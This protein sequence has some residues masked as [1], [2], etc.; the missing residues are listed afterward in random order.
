MPNSFYNHTTYPT[1][2][3]PGSSAQMRAELQLITEAFDKL[4]TLSGAANQLVVVNGAANALTTTTALSGLT[5]TGS[6]INSSTIGASVPAGG[7]FTTLSATGAVSLGSSV[8]IAGGTING[9]QIGNTTP[10]SGAFTTLAA[11]SGITGNLTGNVTGNLTG[12]VTGNL[13]GNVTGNVTASS[14][15]STFTNVTINGTLNM[16]AGTTGTIENLSTPVNSGDAAPKGY[17]DTQVATRLALAGGTMSGAIVMGTNRITGMGDPVDAQDAATKIYV[18][19]AVQG[20]DAK[21]SCRVATTANITLS[22]AQTIDGVSVVAGNRVLVKNQSAAAENGIYVAAS[23]AWSRAPDA[24]TWDEL[25]HAFVFVEQ[26]TDGAN[27][28]YVCTVAAGGTLGTTAVTWVQFSG[29]GQIIA[30]TGLTKTGNTLNVNT[31]SSA[32]IVAGADEI[33]LATTGVVASTYKSVT[34]DQ[35]GRVTAGTNPTTLSGYGITDAYTSTQTDTLLSGKLSL[36]GGTMSGAIA[37]GTNKITG[38]GDPTNAQDAA[39]KNYTDS[40]LGSA[41]SAATSAAAALQ[42]EIN[43]AAS[44]SN[45]QT[46]AGNALTSANNAAA[47]YDAFDDRYLGSKTA[48]PTLDN[49]GNPLLE[50]ALYWNTGAKIMKVYD[51]ANWTASYLPATGYVQKTGDT[52]TGTLTAP[53]FIGPLTGNASTATALQ[54]A[55]TINGVSFDGTANITVADATKLPLTGGTV[56]GD[57]SFNG[58]SI[59]LGGGAI[60][61]NTRAGNLALSS[62]TSGTQNAAF[63]RQAMRLN[64]TGGNN[65]AL[66]NEALY[67]NTTGG[68]STAVGYAALYNSN[69]IGNT[70]VGQQAGVAL[71]SGANN[72]VVGNTALYSNSTGDNNTVVGSNALFNAT[73]T[74]NLA[75]GYFSGSQITT[76]SKNAIV[77]SFNG[78]SGGLDI[79]TANNHVVLSDGDGNIRLAFD[80]GGAMGLAGANYGTAGQVPVS[81]GA[82]LAPVWGSV[83]SEIVRVAR[84]SNTALTSANNG[85]LIDIT[86]GTFTQTFNACSSLGSGWFCYIRNSGTGDVTLDPNA[87][88]TIDG[89]TSFVMYPGEVRL[90]QCD[91]TALRTVVLNAFY[92]TFT[93]SGTFT[94]P[95]GYT[96]FEG[97]LWGAGGSG[98]RNDNGQSCGGGGGGGCTPFFVPNDRLASTETVTIGAGGAS[99]TTSGSG[100][101]GGN[102]QFSSFCFA[103]GG[104][105][106]VNAGDPGKGGNSTTLSVSRSS[107]WNQNFSNELASWTITTTSEAPGASIWA[108]GTGSANDTAPGALSIYGGGGG[109]GG[110][111]QNTAGG[112]STYGGAGGGG[113][114]LQDAVD[115]TAPGGGGGGCRGSGGSTRTGAGARGE[116]RIWGI[117]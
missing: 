83:G 68:S 34:V 16:D 23:G 26:G 41:T 104:G 69:A 17:V 5:I 99:R 50:G 65:T 60:T 33:D 115:G 102:S 73:G 59:G 106:G 55:R 2:N 88:E 56:T 82:G 86:S 39:T 113:G 111:T 32:R 90:V 114:Y 47:S 53:G 7:W 108:G 63:G 84:T 27:N 72:T 100:A 80:N 105:G 58:V 70:A 13:T 1:P 96:S 79:R 107:S 62:N 81:Q 9:T 76:G 49:D 109:S 31:A 54:T 89:L 28:G 74:Q 43:A 8:V 97:L 29:A 40:I 117:I 75:L 18:D 10:S 30:G 42:S 91:G 6:T 14:G 11:S 93:A 116:L 71:T 36:T 67:T 38:L 37:M 94:K 101:A 51:G 64:T 77:G 57:T 35:W 4:P 48:D 112:V 95:P 103:Y 85:N 45:A 25:V 44:E 98:A 61:S 52:M 21:A 20:L 19:N 92:R 15:T 66:G 46:Y 78:N 3:S 24:N 87:S 12:N 110:R 22:G